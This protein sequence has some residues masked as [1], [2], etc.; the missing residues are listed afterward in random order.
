MR[1]RHLSFGPFR[2]DPIEH[3][4]LKGTER[5]TLSPKPLALLSYLVR[6]PGRL[7]TKQELLDALWP[8]VHVG[9]AVLKTC[10]AEIRQTLDD[11]AATPRFIETVQ[12][13]GYRFVAPLQS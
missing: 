11:D 9:D 13:L 2:F 8:G 12:R 7:A 5:L 3:Q 10:V 6:R 1:Q 4:L